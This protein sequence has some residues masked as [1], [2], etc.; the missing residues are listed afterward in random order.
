MA[1]LTRL[2]GEILQLLSMQSALRPRE[3]HRR[4]TQTED[5]K[6]VANA[7]QRMKSAGLVERANNQCWR[8][9][10]AGRT[11]ARLA[12]VPATPPA[13]TAKP[14]SVA[15]PRLQD[16]DVEPSRIPQPL[17][18]V[19]ERAGKTHAAI[20]A[21]Q[22]AAQH[23]QDALDAYVWEVGDADVLQPLMAARD[24]AQQALAAYEKRS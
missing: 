1:K 7:L 18:K 21:L 10:D 5:H 12:A 23:A 6:Q 14:A 22:S 2:Y 16:D 11:E 20:N 19:I 15:T 9:T 8:V 17:A 3:L 4:I 13:P 24:A